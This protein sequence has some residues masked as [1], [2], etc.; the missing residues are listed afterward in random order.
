MGGAVVL[1]ARKWGAFRAFSVRHRYP[2]V[3]AGDVAEHRH[4]LAVAAQP[5]LPPGVRVCH[6]AGAGLAAAITSHVPAPTMT[7]TFAENR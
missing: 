4:A 1:F 2:A 7:C 6:G 3:E 5:G